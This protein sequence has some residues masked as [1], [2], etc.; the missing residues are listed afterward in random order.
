MFTL[1]K[2]LSNDDKGFRKVY[3]GA[4]FGVCLTLKGCD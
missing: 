2:D 3:L 1:G 4:S